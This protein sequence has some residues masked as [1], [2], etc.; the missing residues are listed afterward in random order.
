MTRQLSFALV[1]RLVGDDEPAKGTR[2]RATQWL[3]FEVVN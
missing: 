3:D 1:C 2:A